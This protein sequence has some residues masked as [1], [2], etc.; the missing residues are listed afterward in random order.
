M[1]VLKISDLK[2]YIKII[3]PKRF[4]LILPLFKKVKFNECHHDQ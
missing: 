2:K 1:F 3:F 4:N